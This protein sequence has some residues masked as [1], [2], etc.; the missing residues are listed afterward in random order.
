[1][2]IKDAKHVILI[3]RR[4]EINNGKSIAEHRISWPLSRQYL[5]EYYPKTVDISR[6]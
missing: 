4:D 2:S 3:I 6:N 5:Q 1:M